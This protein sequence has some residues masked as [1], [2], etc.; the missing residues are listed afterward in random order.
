MTNEE[1]EG[2][3]AEGDEE[4]VLPAIAGPVP[5]RRGRKRKIPL[6]DENQKPAK[7]DVLPPIPE[8][9]QIVSIFSKLFT[10][11]IYILVKKYLFILL[12]YILIFIYYNI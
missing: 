3:G 9:P 1:L 5:G 8:V 6:D 11:N 10:N 12:S 7:K 4:N 2:E